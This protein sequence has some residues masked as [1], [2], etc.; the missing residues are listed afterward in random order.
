VQALFWNYTPVHAEKQGA[1][2][3][4]RDYPPAQL[5]PVALD[6][7]G[8]KA[9]NYELLVR[10]VGYRHNDVYTDYLDLQTTESLTQPQV[11]SLAAKNNGDPEVKQRVQINSDGRFIRT[12]EMRE[13]DVY[14]VTLN[15][16]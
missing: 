9:G 13:N 7:N 15:R 5:P 3:W 10:R 8:V 12:F 16:E 14:F 4:A 11:R 1:A 6:L 2:P